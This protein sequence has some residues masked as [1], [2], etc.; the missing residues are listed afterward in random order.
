MWSRQ[1][2]PL[3]GCAPALTASYERFASRAR[4]RYNGRA[5]RTR[6]T[7]RWRAR[8]LV[9]TALALTCSAAWAGVETDLEQGIG[10]LLARVFIAQRGQLSQPPIDA[11]IGSIGEE[12]VACAPR[13]DLHYRFVVLDSPESNGFAL[14]GGWIFVTAGLLESAHGDDEIA[15]VMAHEVAHLVDRDFQRMVG[16]TLLWLGVAELVR[17]S[18]RDDLLP[19]VQGA[20]L[21][22]TLRHSRRQ[23]A[24]AD[25]VGAAIA[26]RA[27]YDPS[28]LLHFLDS[29]PN[30]SY[31]ETVF[32]THPPPKRRAI[33]IERRW[34]QLRA[35]DPAGVVRLARGLMNRCRYDR[36]R[37]LLTDADVKTPVP[38]DIA[39]ERAALLARIET[40]MAACDRGA[41]GEAALP[42]EMADELTAAG[43]ELNAAREAAEPTRKLAWCRLRALWDDS[44]VQRAAVAANALDP[45]LTDPAYLMLLAQAADLLHRAV[46][47]GNL[48]ARTLS[49]RASAAGGVNTLCA[50]L[51]APRVSPRHL[52]ILSDTAAQ[53]GRLAR[54]MAAAAGPDTAALARLGT[55][56]L[57]AA[58]LA[59][60]L[61][62][63]LASAGEG[64]SLGALNFSRYL[65]MQAQVTALARRQDD[66][67]RQVNALAAR[68]WEH[69]IMV[70]RLRLNRA[71]LLTVPAI[72]PAL[73]RCL[74]WRAGTSAGRLKSRWRAQ[75]GLGDA[76]L[77]EL[78]EALIG[79]REGFGSQQRAAYIVL[80]LSFHDAEEKVGTEVNICESEEVPKRALGDSV[81]HPQ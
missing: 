55:D 44:M 42:A 35:Q 21:I 60:P 34:D 10:D 64:D 16:R 26:W 75:G 9:L 23:E 41:G 54:E 69:G 14:P 25:S 39:A 71:G 51:K 40:L 38:Q 80:R 28:T 63:E 48:V 30:W 56:Y 31:L 43:D 73:L 8:A 3:L 53:T 6:Q 68:A 72:R 66:L 7:G 36:A 1:G 46:R 15:A 24:Q 76:L 45:E 4:L 57:R 65:V 49:M 77:A 18:D 20:Q 22:N 27:G 74:A 17:R 32:A 70:A 59:A 52:S 50:G 19:L 79:S 5:M 61:L 29:S 13:R 12:L 78:D 11:W 58:R 81:G 2:G 33:W 47:G 37:A 62:M 67:D